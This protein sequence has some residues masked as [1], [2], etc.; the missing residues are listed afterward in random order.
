MQEL[1]ALKLILLW[2]QLLPIIDFNQ[3]S[4]FAQFLNKNM[5]NRLTP[6]QSFQ[7]NLQE[8]SVNRNSPCELVRELVSNSYD[9]E[10]KNIL[11]L[12]FLKR[13]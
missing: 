11:V 12:R 6:K 5:N 4:I 3:S 2:P 13:F 7:H 9:A 8:I 1:Q 10:A